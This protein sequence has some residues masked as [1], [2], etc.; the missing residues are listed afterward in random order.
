MFKPFKG[1]RKAESVVE[2]VLGAVRAG[3][4]TPGARL[5]DENAMAVEFQVSRN[6]VRE[7]LRI[8]ETMGVVEVRHGRGCF[9]AER[10]DPGEPSKVWL[11]WLRAFEAEVLELLEVREAIE[12]KAAQLAAIHATAEDLVRLED[13]AE[14][15]ATAAKA[16]TTGTEETARLDRAFHAAVAA[17]S[18]NSFLLK[19][20]PGSWGADER[21]ATFLMEGRT[22][23]SARQHQEVC[24]AIAARDPVAAGNAMSR[25][26][27]DVIDQVLAL[28]RQ[29]AKG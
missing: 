8:L 9:V 24:A 17:A 4:L 5:P 7:A 18:G 2:Q 28:N 12:A 29:E 21:Q 26:L 23:L 27:R 16:Q 10:G 20:A 22:L 11:S 1:V 25:H 13:L 3:R 6:C 15:M 19:L 14:R